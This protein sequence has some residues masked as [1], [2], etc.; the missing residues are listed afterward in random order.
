MV[1]K[2]LAKLTNTPE[3]FKASIAFAFASIIH[4]GLQIITTP[5]YTR[6][7]STDEVGQVSVYLTWQRI[8]GICAMFCLSYGVF[9]NGM[10]DFEKER[11]QYTLSMQT[12]SNLITVVFGGIALLFY[13]YFRASIGISTTLL[14]WMFIVFLLQP[15]MNFWTAR[16]RYEYKYKAMTTVTIS[17]AFLSSVT[18]VLF[19]SKNAFNEKTT[20]RI[21]GTEMVMVAFYLFFYILNFVKA[22]GKI[23]TKYWGYALR[24]NI[25]LIPHYLS[26]Y[27]LGHSNNIMIERMQGDTQ[28]ALY[29]VAYTGASVA[30]V[31]W[32]SINV[33]LIPY[34]YEKCKKNDYASIAKITHPLL[35]IYAGL[36][37]FVS[38]FAPEAVSILAP[39]EYSDSVYAFP[40]LMIG[41]F[42]QSL[43]YVFANIVYYHKKP[44]YVMI[45]SVVATILNIALNLLIIPRYGFIAAGYVTMICYILQAV[46]DFLAMRKV[47]GHNVYNIKFVCIL[48]FFMLLFSVFVRYIYPLTILRYLFIGSG[49][50]LCF[51]KRKN[52]IALITSVKKTE[53]EYSS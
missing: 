38:L 28:V 43:Y 17:M 21:F 47:V 39:K 32:T 3:N 35:A 49:I 10:L 11:D 18:T 25:V 41:V 52:I 29:S 8:L 42:F 40:A 22:K 1:R 2:G 7:L 5:I 34:T 16:Q 19:I 15:A 4:M 50:I 23:I 37:I 26:A 27:L 31:I 45:A 9:N 51:A 14:L 6:L 30:A 24:F 13:P 12:L 44:K 36:C 33:S 48:S 20:A 53:E 46:I